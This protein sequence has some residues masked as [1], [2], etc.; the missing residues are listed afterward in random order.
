MKYGGKLW[1]Q[2]IA[3]SQVTQVWAMAVLAAI[4]ALC[5]VWLLIGVIRKRHK[6]RGVLKEQ[7]SMA[8]CAIT[9]ELPIAAVLATGHFLNTV[10]DIV[11]C[12]SEEIIP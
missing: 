4:L 8:D 1:A 5:L 12:E 6:H 7:S 11:Y 2:G 3:M 10:E 9:Q